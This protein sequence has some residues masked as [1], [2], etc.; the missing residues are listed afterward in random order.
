M[1]FVCVSIR[2][3]KSGSESLGHLLTIAFAGHRIFYLPTTLDRDGQLSRMQRLRF[4]RSQIKN[5]LAYYWS[6]SLR[7][8]YATIDRDAQGGDLIGGGHLDFPNVKAALRR[9]VKMIALLREPIARVASE[10]NYSRS[11]YFDRSPLRRATVATLPAVAGR[12]D[13]D[14]YLDF[15]EE[16]RAIYGDPASRYTGWNGAEDLTSFCVR[17]VFHIGILERRQHFA[18]GLAEKLGKTLSFP[19]ENRTESESALNITP[20]RRAKIERIFARDFV[21]YEWVKANC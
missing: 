21:F 17:D 1:D 4:R 6:P 5:L 11:I 13:F 10:Y 8:A 12:Y 19:H 16:N 2:I 20:S 9:P 7:H 3:P 14:G 18:D 15:I